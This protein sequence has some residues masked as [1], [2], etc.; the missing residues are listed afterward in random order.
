[1]AQFLDLYEIRANEEEKRDDDE[2]YYEMAIQEWYNIHKTA[3][4][5]SVANRP[6]PTPYVY[7]T[8]E[9]GELKRKRTDGVINMDSILGLDCTS[10]KKVKEEEKIENNTVCDKLTIDIAIKI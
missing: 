7:H 3:F 5:K 4:L 8:I 6:H 1:M 9:N 10:S 2:V